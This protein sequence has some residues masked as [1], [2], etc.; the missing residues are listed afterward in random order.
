MNFIFLHGQSDTSRASAKYFKQKLMNFATF[1]NPSFTCSQQSSSVHCTFC[2]TDP[3]CPVFQA[4]LEACLKFLMRRSWCL[5]RNSSDFGVKAVSNKE[6]KI[7]VLH[8][9]ISHPCI[10]EARLNDPET[11]RIPGTWVERKLFGFLCSLWWYYRTWLKFKFL[12]V[13]L[14]PGYYFS[15]ATEI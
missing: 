4:L 10:A 12:K 1:P 14:K 5:D 8:S 11:L 9:K 2:F 15:L 3:L 13:F 7:S 6:M